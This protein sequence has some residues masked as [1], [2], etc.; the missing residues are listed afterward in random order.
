M[1]DVNKSNLDN[2]DKSAEK[3]K[4]LKEIIKI[5]YSRRKYR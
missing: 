2:K 3:K 5:K 1:K 4:T